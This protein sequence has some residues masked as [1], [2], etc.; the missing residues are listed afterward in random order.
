MPY[1]E[2]ASEKL[3]RVRSSHKLR[4]SLYTENT[5]HKLFYKHKVPEVTEDKKNIAYETDCSDCETVYFSESK[6]SLK[7]HSD[8]YLDEQKNLSEILIAIIMKLQNSDWKQSTTLT[9]TRRK[10]LIEKTG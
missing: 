9:G 7:S 1:V 2:G 8:E 6:Q 5:L 4:F 10:L 3:R